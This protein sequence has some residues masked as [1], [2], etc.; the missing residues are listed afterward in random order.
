LKNHRKEGGGVPKKKGVPRIASGHSEINR[1]KKK[2]RRYLRRLGI[3]GGEGREKEPKRGGK[4]SV[5]PGRCGNGWGVGRV[6]K[7]LL[8]RREGF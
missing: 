4:L 6:V 5:K 7:T 2:T 1:H 3:P 8:G